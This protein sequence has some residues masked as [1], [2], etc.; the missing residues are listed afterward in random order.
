M[1]RDKFKPM[2]SSDKASV[3]KYIETAME[4]LD[5]AYREL[6]NSEQLHYIMDATQRF[7]DVVS[8][9]QDVLNKIQPYAA[10]DAEAAKLAVKLGMVVFAIQLVQQKLAEIQAAIAGATQPVLA[11]QPTATAMRGMGVQ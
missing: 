5:R 2:P 3:E 10:T 4:Q 1:I 6:S 7:R 9:L 11:Q 8:Q